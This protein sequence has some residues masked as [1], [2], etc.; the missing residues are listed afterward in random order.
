M[1]IIYPKDLEPRNPEFNILLL[2]SVNENGCEYSDLLTEKTKISESSVNRYL[3]KLSNELYIQK[4][5]INPKGESELNVYKITNYGLKRLEKIKSLEYSPEYPPE[6][7]ITQFNHKEKIIYMLNKN[8]FC[9]WGNFVDERLNIP[10]STLSYKLKD[11]QDKEYLEKVILK[12]ITKPVYKILPKGRKEF[13]DILKKFKFDPETIRNETIKRIEE[14]SFENKTFFDEYSIS[15]KNIQYQFKKYKLLLNQ[16][17]YRKIFRSKNLFNLTLLFLSHNHP[18]HFKGSFLT[19]E[20][21]CNRFE[22]KLENLKYY[23]VELLE[24]ELAPFKIFSLKLEDGINLYFHEKE[25]IGK[26]LKSVIEDYFE[27][28]VSLLPLKVMGDD[29]R[30]KSS[31]TETDLVNLVD[32][33]LDKHRLFN[34]N[35]RKEVLK[36]LPK[37]INFLAIKIESKQKKLVRGVNKVTG[38]IDSLELLKTHL[39][40]SEIPENFSIKERDLETPSI[41]NFELEGDFQL[42]PLDHE[43]LYEVLEFFEDSTKWEKENFSKAL[44]IFENKF[45]NEGEETYYGNLC[46]LLRRVEK[47]DDLLKTSKKA[48]SYYPDHP[49]FNYFM[50]ISLIETAQYSEIGDFILSPDYL[51]EISFKL[52]EKKQ[53]NLA[54][55]FLEE[56][57]YYFPSG[58][59]MITNYRDQITKIIS[60]EIKKEN[61][62]D[63]L[64]ILELI[65]FYNYQNPE[66]HELKIELLF[67]LKKYNEALEAVN[68]IIKRRPKYPIL[69]IAF[70][71]TD[72]NFGYKFFLQ[73]ARI[74]NVLEKY[75]ES[76]EVINSV[77]KLNSKIMRAYQISAISFYY[78]QDYKNA[79]IQIDKA[80]NLNPEKSI[81]YS[82]KADC[83]FK[84]NKLKDALTQID[85]ALKLDSNIPENY[86]IKSRILLFMNKHDES[87]RTIN[88]GIEKF[89]ENPDLHET[90]SLIIYRN[91]V[92]SLKALEIAESLGG[93]IS[94]Y[95]KA[96]LLDNLERHEEAL[97]IIEKEINAN[98]ESYGNYDMKAWILM[99]MK[100]FEEALKFREKSLNIS[101]FSENDSGN[102]TEQIL[103]RYAVYLAEKGEKKKAIEVAKEAVELSGPKWASNSYEAF[104]DIFIVFKEYQEALDKYEKAKKSHIPSNKIN[105]K[106]GICHFKLGNYE[107]SLEFLKVAKLQGEHSVSAQE[108]GK[109]GIRVQKP[110]PQKDIID[111]A[112]KYITKIEEI[113]DVKK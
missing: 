13:I 87:L 6:G 46:K 100:Q 18:N 35:L 101:G 79:I 94:L 70:D 89:P 20:E 36:F 47:F 98:P 16:T 17:D 30:K 66:F 5:N 22:L 42:K 38:E 45:K 107:K 12:G 11:L 90:K 86:R 113:Y 103:C 9:V 77:L 82:I 99:G 27:K 34:D 80:I 49:T 1:K 2:L 43:K 41:L 78:L 93:D 3:R 102:I 96:Q 95:N 59:I 81:Y 64:T 106:I 97:E 55:K 74:L 23:I 51:G 65:M 25:K 32:L 88:N 108:V 91:N 15:D 61:F 33:V 39:E 68:E 19:E 44:E 85:I 57:Y 10:K 92:E 71:P 69:D 54:E 56:S 84:D 29:K 76:I 50:I 31:F 63:S 21:F 58:D 110:I 14:I 53:Y 60:N 4:E 83:F 67:E 37:Y 52:I 62:D 75:E 109:D 112:S 8:S 105:L 48:L 28:N 73:K 104:G 26:M 111:E 24:E 7:Y 40:A 72:D